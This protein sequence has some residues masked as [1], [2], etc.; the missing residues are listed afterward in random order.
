MQKTYYLELANCGL[1]GT[2]PT[3]LGLMTM[4]HRLWLNSNDFTGTIPSEFG[5]FTGLKLGMDLYENPLLSGTIPTELGRLTALQSLRLHSNNLLGSIPSEF[6]NLSSLG[7]LLLNNN[8]LKGTIP[9]ELSALEGMLHS[10][11]LDGNGL[12]TGVIPE[13][14]CNLIQTASCASSEVAPCDDA[15]GISFDCFNSSGL[16]GCDCICG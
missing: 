6:G 1:T 2:I 8:S 14:L 7:L 9:Q 5:Q 3:E 4:W 11:A 16:C 12:L 13:S 10:V 15:F